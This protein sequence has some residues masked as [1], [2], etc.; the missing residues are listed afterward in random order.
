V[1]ALLTDYDES[2]HAR[3]GNH[4]IQDRLARFDAVSLALEDDHLTTWRSDRQD[5]AGDV[6]RGAGPLGVSRAP[7]GTSWVA[8][9]G[10]DEIEEIGG[11]QPRV[12]DT[13][14]FGLSAPSA[15]VE[16]ADD[17]L[18][19]TSPSS[20][21][22]AV[23]GPDGELV[24]SIALAPGDAELLA[25]DPAALQLRYGER[26]FYEATRSGVSCASCHLHGGTDGTTHNIGGRIAAPTLDVRGLAGTSPYLRDGSYPRLRDLHEVAVT[27]YRGYR[28]AAG[29]RGATVEAWLRTLPLPRTSQA[30]APELEREGLGIFVRAGCVECHAAPAFTSLGLHAIDAVFPGAPVR[31][32]G[33]LLDVPSLRGVAGSAPYL[34][35]ARAPTLRD[36]LTTQNPSDRHGHTQ[37][38]SAAELDALEAFLRSL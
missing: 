1:W 16:L 15:V 14:R 32:E 36:L 35:D 4:F 27:E 2:G 34:Y 10:T 3:L 37:S 11:P 13:A 29:D 22:I 17:S 6:D 8:F 7:R 18:V 30:R 31:T 21:Q 38:L 26:A 23:L 12:V 24:R 5:H 25:S 9:A 19:V 20:G 33:R 28:E